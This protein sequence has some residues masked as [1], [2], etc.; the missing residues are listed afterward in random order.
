MDND[1][2]NLTGCRIMLL[3]LCL[4][5]GVPSGL[6]KQLK[7]REA[8]RIHFGSVFRQIAILLPAYGNILLRIALGSDAVVV[9]DKIK[10]VMVRLQLVTRAIGFHS[11]EEI[12]V[13]VAPTCHLFVA[14][15]DR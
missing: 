6:V 8:A 7:C 12:G 14:A 13:L 1:S 9:G 11:V 10:I 4:I 2:S 5:I 3:R 15:A